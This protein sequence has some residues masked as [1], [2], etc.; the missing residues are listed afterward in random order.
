MR[1]MEGSR[2][3]V[4]TARNVDFIHVAPRMGHSMGFQKRFDGQ[5]APTLFAENAIHI[6][7]FAIDIQ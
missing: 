6:L 2:V 7:I 5:C 4:P 3:M 1:K